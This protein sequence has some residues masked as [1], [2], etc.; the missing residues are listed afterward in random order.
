MIYHS[1]KHGPVEISK[2]HEKHVMNALEKL[3]RADRSHSS[4][5]SFKNDYKVMGALEQRLDEL[6]HEKLQMY[7]YQVRVQ[8]V[9]V[10][11]PA[12]EVVVKEYTNFHGDYNKANNNFSL[13]QAG[14][15]WAAKVD[16]SETVL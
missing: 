6:L 14:Y 10:D 5:I 12:G 2:M 7:P 1:S 16:R 9:K 8:I 15:S 4:L 13:V 11:D 3:K